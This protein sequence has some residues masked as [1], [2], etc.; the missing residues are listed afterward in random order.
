[1]P[2]AE[3]TIIDSNCYLGNWPTRSLPATTAVELAAMARDNGIDSCL[4]SPLDGIF[5][6]NTTA[7]NEK[8]AQMLAGFEESMVPLPVV[9]PASPI[10][11]RPIGGFFRLAP[12]YHG[13]STRNRKC[14]S[15][16]ADA[17]S[18]G[19]LVLLSLRMRDERL[20]H[21]LFRPKRVNLED[22]ISSARGI[23][24]IRLVVNNAKPNEMEEILRDAP[25]G[26]MVG[27]EWSMPVGFLE[28]MVEHYGDWR[29][30]YGSNAPLHY[31]QC[32]LLQVQ[33][34]DIPGESKRRIL[35]GNLAEHLRDIAP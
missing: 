9:N 20:N 19:H 29:L 31:H 17:A 24:D 14:R 27:C 4:V 21:S 33:Q 15:V 28:R 26:T 32:S 7:A 35:G 11:G 1:M 2:W 23:K 6:T 16:L 8:L 12:S 10:S 13:Y 34:A 25:D 22:L 30:I 3:G 18:R 5:H